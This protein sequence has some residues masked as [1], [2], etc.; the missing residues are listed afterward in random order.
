MPIS[1]RTALRQLGAFGGLA[2]AA[3][4]THAATAEAPEFSGANSAEPE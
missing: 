4:D 2:V 1:R 3:R